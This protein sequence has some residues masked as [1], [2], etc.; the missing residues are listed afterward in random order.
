MLKK[1]LFI[2]LSIVGYLCYSQQDSLKVKKYVVEE[3]KEVVVVSKKKAVIQK[4]DRTIFDFSS[5]PSLNSGSLANGLIKLPGLIISDV[6]GMVFQGKELEVYIDGR[7]LNIYVEELNSY[8]EGMPANSIDRVEII[9]Q[10]GAEFPATSGGAIINIITLKKSESYLTATYGNGFSYTH[11]D[12]DRY[13]FNKNITL[14]AKNKLFGWQ[15]RVGQNYRENFRNT[16]FSVNEVSLSNS[17]SERINRFY[18]IESG[19]KFDL[20]RD[21]VLF[22][23]NYN[24]NKNGADIDAFGL[25]FVAN[26]NSKSNRH[27]NDFSLNYQKRFEDYTKKLDFRLNYTN[28]DNTTYLYNRKTQTLT[29]NNSDIQ[30]FYQF[31]TD[32]SQEFEWFGN[33]KASVGVLTNLLDFRA[34]NFGVRNL[35]YTQKT[36]SAYAEF[37]F[38]YKD[39]DLILGG[40][41]E[42]YKIEGTTDTDDLTPFEQTRFFP[43][44]SLQYNIIP[45]VFINANYNRKINLPN[46][47]ELNPNNTIYENPNLGFN[48]N[49]NL[50]PSIFDS[51]SLKLSAHEYFYIEYSKIDVDNQIT[52]RIFESG[53]NINRTSVN[54]PNV[55]IRNFNFGIPIPF[56]LFTKGMSKTLEFD[57]NPDEIS[58]LYL[59]VGYQKQDIPEI[60]SKGIWTINLITQI[61]LPKKINFTTTFNTST[62]YGNYYYYNFIRP[63]NQSLDV[64]ISKDFF[65]DDLSVSINLNDLINTDKTKLNAIGTEVVFNRN[66]DSRRIGFSLVY[67]IPFNR[68]KDVEEDVIILKKS[69][70]KNVSSL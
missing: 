18:Y 56:M 13:Q 57:Y 67:K 60:E 23:Y 66:Y 8:L 34:K 19:L 42:S 33:T 49:P 30:N 5:Q 28:N 53:N 22:N 3:L 35:D 68:K 31:R 37:Q 7:P 1:T 27:R 48:G 21:R 51:Y 2:T 59:N 17:F 47:S 6:T 29:L 65:N 12:K 52:S 41:L 40:R 55:S 16:N 70:E 46:V 4:A 54:I 43:N 14:N 64:N 20:K 15:L 32:Y 63:L 38:E 62:S 69:K 45:K 50:E 11:Y 25:G 44:A 10:P 9:T 26:D 61:I 58:F 39:F 36:E 24:T